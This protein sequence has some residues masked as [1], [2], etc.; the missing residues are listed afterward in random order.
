MTTRSKTGIRKPNPRY[1]LVAS[2]TIPS[3]PQTVADALAH[4][5]WH[6]AMIEELDSIY[7][8]HTWS[9]TPAT[10]E[11]NILGCRWIFTV[12][13]NADGS[14]NKLKARLVA[15]GFKQEEGV[16][17]IETYSPVVRTSTIRIV[18]AVATSLDWSI[19]QLDVKNAFLHGDLHEPVYM[20]QPPG[21]EDHTILHHV[22]SLKKAFYGLKQDP[23]AW[24]DK[25]TH[26]L[27]EYGCLQ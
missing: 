2:K 19:T 9:L 17:F 5:G 6:Q 3:L 18:L 22:C 25:F 4:P 1:A 23:R 8:N 20:V 16:D 7:Q 11:M 21:F 15:K 26:F 12:K 27:I 13:L 14:L 10:A 24:F